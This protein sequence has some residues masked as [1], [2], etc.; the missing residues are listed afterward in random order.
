ML[1]QE[2]QSAGQLLDLCIFGRDDGLQ[3]FALII[4]ELLGF[5]LAARLPS[6]LEDHRLTLPFPFFFCL[7]QFPSE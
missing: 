5:G 2:F 1:L 3:L 7:F 6:C 4:F